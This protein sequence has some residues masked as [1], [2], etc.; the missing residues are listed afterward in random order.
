M[1]VVPETTAQSV[2][3]SAL[4]DAVANGLDDADDDNAADGK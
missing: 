2:G 4:E 1:W 3:P